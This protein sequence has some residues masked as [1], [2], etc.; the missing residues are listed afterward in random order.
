M[1]DLAGTTGNDT[2][3]GTAADEQIRTGGGTDVVAAGD[4]NDWVNCIVNADGSIGY[5]T[6]AGSATIDGGAGN[7]FLYGTTGNDV[8]KGGIDDDYLN[9]S[10]GDDQLD[11]GAGSDTLYGGIGNDS[12][13]GGDG[14]DKLYD[15][16]SGNDTL[17]GGFG[18]DYLSTYGSTGDDSLDGG[19]GSDTLYG[20]IGND[21][22]NGGDGNDK[23]YDQTS[24]NDTLLGGFGDDYLS[25][26]G[27]TG[28]DSLDGG[29]GNDTLYGGTGND[30][31]IGG[32]GNDYLG[33][34][35]GNN[36]L[37][38]G[39]GSDT[40]YGDIGNDTLSGG[41]GNDYL[42]GLD[43][44]DSL[45][46]GAGNDT[47]YGGA[48]NDTLIGGTGF[49]VLSGGNGDD[50]YKIS[51]RDFY[52]YDTGGTDT[53]IVSTS[54]VKLPQSIET[55]TYTD[56][57]MALPY[58]I[59]D[60]LAGD[61]ARFATLLGSAKTMNFTFP[62]SLPSYDT[63]T[64]HALGYL[65][66][67]TEQQ[68]FAR[69][70]LNYVSTVVDLSFVATSI[71][72]ATNT[73]TFA[74]NTQTGS[75][76]YATYPDDSLSGNDLFLNRDTAG[77]LMP[78]DGTYAAY[79]LIHELGH[80]FGLKHVFSNVDSTGTVDAGPYLPASEENTTWTVMSYTD[81]PAQYHLA[82]SPLDIAALQ[83]LYGP[84]KTA[85]A[86]N[87][88]YTLSTT[89]PNF[90]WDG[91]GTDTLSAS[92]Q[93]Q[94]VTLYLEPG[95]WGYIGSKAANITASG[96]VT[97]NFGTVIENLIGGSGNDTLYGNDA[98]NE[99]DGGAGNDV[100]YGGGGNDTFNWGAAARIGNDTFYGGVGD[101]T[102]VLSSSLDSV[103]EYSGEGTDVVWVDFSFSLAN[104]PNI[105]IL[106][107]YGSTGLTLTGNAAS[108]L[109][110]GTTGNDTIDGGTGN[111][112]VSY[113]GVRASYAIAWIT[114]GVT[115][116]STV[117]GTDTLKNVEFAIFSDQIISLAADTAPTVTTFS[118]L[119]EAI[120]VSLASNIVVT[121]NEAIQRG[122][123]S[124]LLKT[125]GGTTVATYDAA[126]SANL[127]ISGSTLTINPTAD[128]AYSTGYKV[129]FAAGVIKDLA[130]NSYAGTTSYNFTTANGVPVATSATVSAVE[131]TAKTGTLT[132]TD[133]EGS[134]LTFA[135]FADP[136]HGTVTINASTGAYVYTPASNY[137]GADSF[138]FKVNDG[139]A[140]SAASTV[141]I[142]VSAV[143]DPPTGTVTI[144]GTVTQGQTLTGANT[145]ADVDGL[146]T[147]SYQWKAA[148]VNIAGANA[149]MFTL[150]QA[151]VGK[152][153]TVS[154]S[155]TDVMGTAES[156]TS[157]PTALV[158]DTTAPTVTTFSPID[159]ATGIGV[160][161]NIVVT[162]N[163]AIQRGGGTIILKTAADTTVATYDAATN[164]ELSI[165]GN[166][167]TINPT[168]D[169]AYGIN[170]KVEFAGGTVKDLAGNSYAG[171]G[172]YNFTT[173]SMLISGGAG[174][175]ILTGTTGADLIYGNGGDDR[176]TGMGGGD[177]IYGGSGIDTVVFAY[178]SGDYLVSKSPTTGSYEVISK[179]GAIDYV[180][181][182][183]EK[184]AFRDITVDSASYKYYGTTDPVLAGSVSSVYRF[185]NTNDNAFFYT[186][187]VTERDTVLAN[188]DVSHNN[189]GEW[190]YVYQGSS[191]EAAHS[192]AGAVP[193]ERFYNT[194]TH[195]HF[196]TSSATEA[197]TVKANSASGA[198]PFVYEGVSLYVYASDPTPNGVGQEIAVERF[199][200]ASLNRHWFTA[201]QTEIAQIRLTGLWVD[202]GIGFWGEKPGA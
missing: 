16:T 59:D 42:S 160:D 191:F 47:L 177:S 101:D 169:L 127:S 6:Y 123:G 1:A 161:S 154:A 7:D 162:F 124:I 139:T 174:N 113:A 49:D 114:G 192:Y 25:T 167:L 145:L 193:L 88:T 38:G 181:A 170:Y 34:F 3:N 200:S 51:S 53:A 178:D 147:I 171:T 199:Y 135:K 71:A 131:D 175:D 153:I 29:A 18:D 91:T 61:A 26:Y 143:N 89:A 22:L 50:T 117:D 121:F 11:G 43:G 128:L 33:G 116:T 126:T 146:G 111:D 70:A 75:A 125:A 5:Y 96:Q 78:V 83:Y 198:W 21:S 183:L 138:T 190:P 73:I 100:L 99:I 57:A 179:T 105:E 107:A 60:L 109:I 31:L 159:K 67:T 164:A 120:S 36:N 152:V 93:S 86:G 134:T 106:R 28:D 45:D 69:L 74:N 94:P 103:I 95:Y 119:D 122:T 136:T 172:S 166:T 90:I 196:F 24:G 32:D 39:A 184:M 55:V 64:A 197:A 148:G 186:N 56:G 48:G 14:N 129:E 98:E 17:L 156:K 63:S 20:G 97:V 133:P 151:E 140:D 15:Q 141:S 65:P 44:N 76:G 149:N 180:D 77:N 80:T 37:D 112:T 68:A 108:N 202:E 137:N 150:T 102:F 19:A 188:S 72:A 8:L 130:G 10:G 155:Y 54:F 58:W 185:F 4:G 115:V 189:V 163:E 118:P 81:Y 168:S 194:V 157:G 27:S 66:F 9:G 173:V 182:D 85:R 142:A 87:D 30:T 82:Y 12:L 41:D 132:G 84:S 176:I 23:L 165:V 144:S 46:G 187:S 40:L 35:A 52:L 62:T 201:D 13:N 195:H 104:L 92:S 110:R 79:V 2:L 158:L